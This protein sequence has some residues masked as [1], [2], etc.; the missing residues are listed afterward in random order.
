MVGVG[1]GKEGGDFPEV[2]DW[3]SQGDRLADVGL[4]GGRG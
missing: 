4:G 3:N 1:E 2:V